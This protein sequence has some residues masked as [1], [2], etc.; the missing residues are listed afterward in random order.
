MILDHNPDLGFNV[1][2]SIQGL[3]IVPKKIAYE[4]IHNHSLPI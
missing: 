1:V 2:D 3:E 4:L